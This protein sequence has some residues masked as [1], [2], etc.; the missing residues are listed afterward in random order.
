MCY[1]PIQ[2]TSYRMMQHIATCYYMK[3]TILNVCNLLMLIYHGIQYM[4]SDII[5]YHLYNINWYETQLFYYIL[6][7]NVQ[8]NYILF[9]IL[10]CTTEYESVL[11]CIYVCIYTIY[12]ICVHM[13]NI[14]IYM[15]MYEYVAL[16]DRYTWVLLLPSIM[17]GI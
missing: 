4:F 14:Y 8:N 7:P 12:N 3:H 1:T 15:S 5:T 17:T 11:M 6:S 10:L 13:Y 2:I 16:I 9:I